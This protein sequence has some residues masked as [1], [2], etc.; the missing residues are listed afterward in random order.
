MTDTSIDGTWTMIMGDEEADPD[1]NAQ[2]IVVGDTAWNAETPDAIGTC[3]LVDG[4]MTITLRAVDE[5][6][7]LWTETVT[8]RVADGRGL[9]GTIHTAGPDGINFSDP[10]ILVRDMDVYAKPKGAWTQVGDFIKSRGND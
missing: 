7:Q 5:K 1:Q 10:C 6:G 3:S 2:I 4:L 8:A 9:S